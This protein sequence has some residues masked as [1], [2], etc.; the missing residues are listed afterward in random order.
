MK[1]CAI[2]CE[3]NPFHNGHLYQI[4]QSKVLS[5]ADKILCLMSGNFVQR[6]ESAILDKFLRA[7]HA[8][9]AGADIVLEL[10]TIFATSSAEFFAKGG[11][12]ILNSIPAVNTLCFGSEI[13]D[14]NTFLETAKQLNNE[15]KEVSA[16]IKKLMDGGMSYAKARAQAW[17]NRIHPRLLRSP[18]AILGIEYT[19]AIE[20]LNSSIEI[21]PIE[22]KGNGYC[23]EELSGEFSSASAI[24]KAIQANEPLQNSL[25]EFV[26]QDLPTQTENLLELLEK[27]A[28]LSKTKE[29]ISKVCDCNEGLENALKKA[30][31]SPLRLTD[32]LTSAR[33]TTSR[34]RRI[35][36]QNLLS[37][38]KDFIQECL[39]SPLY[40]RI[41]AMHK[42]D[43]ELLSALSQS[44]YPLIVR[45][46]DM[47]KLTGIAKVCLEK[48]LYAESVYSLLYPTEQT[49]KNIF[50]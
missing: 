21:L 10:P 19:R 41:L 50:F 13:A 24:R 12:K 29:Q 28:I 48:D 25:P 6:G 5:G 36:L 47:E 23:D 34:I 9:L 42:K 33:Y 30:A 22:R 2:I 14:A 45:N 46:N 27:H 26:V 16:C 37:I 11:I 49:N 43:D 4:Q 39:S 1:I 32:T 31:L 20:K 44:I 3:Y 7:K 18:N 17:E 8:L 15:P 38:E 40:L 35:A